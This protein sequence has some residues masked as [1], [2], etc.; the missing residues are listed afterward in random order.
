MGPSKYRVMR[1][2][3]ECS[4]GRH[5]VLEMS[6]WQWRLNA[7]GKGYH[8]TPGRYIAQGDV[9]WKIIRLT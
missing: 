2:R 5:T 6:E 3:E 9:A 4:K 8:H 7:V 1:L